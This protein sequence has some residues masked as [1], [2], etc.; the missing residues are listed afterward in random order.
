MRHDFDWKIS[1]RHKI[2]WIVHN[3]NDH[4]GLHAAVYVLNIIFMLDKIMQLNF[5]KI[6][7]PLLIPLGFSE[8]REIKYLNLN[9]V[10]LK[11][12]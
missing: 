8:E 9:F 12:T 4:N 1:Q 10:D 2:K 7:F 3:H 6:D 11:S 5:K